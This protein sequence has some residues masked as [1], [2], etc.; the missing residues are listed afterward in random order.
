M[1]ST[2]FTIHPG[3][4]PPPENDCWLKSVFCVFK[5]TGFTSSTFPIQPAAMTLTNTGCP[6]RPGHCDTWRLVGS[7][8]PYL[9]AGLGIGW[10]GVVSCAG[11][12][13]TLI[14]VAPPHPPLSFVNFFWFLSW[15]N[16][17]SK[18]RAL[19]PWLGPAGK[20]LHVGQG[21][22]VASTILKLV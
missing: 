21:A 7:I 2:Y 20:Y 11:L 17:I 22:A 8:A 15:I 1:K 6:R 9:Q 18:F 14:G 5:S 3:K 16:K 13:G 19:P 4:S 12:H 10:S